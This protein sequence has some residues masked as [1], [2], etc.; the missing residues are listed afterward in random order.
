MLT[1]QGGTVEVA[2]VEHLH[3][4]PFPIKEVRATYPALSDGF[5]YLDG[6]AGTQTPGP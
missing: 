4:M 6:A 2:K 1:G 5:A 3:I